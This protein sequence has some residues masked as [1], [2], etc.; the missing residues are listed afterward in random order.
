MRKH[1]PGEDAMGRH[2]GIGNGTADAE[3]VGIVGN[4]NYS[5]LDALPTPTM[6]MP[7]TQDV[8]SGMWVLAKTSGDPMALSPP[9]PEC[10]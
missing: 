2:I 4:V 3:I 6:Y 10:P 1:Y 5:G 9:C 8:F 7:T